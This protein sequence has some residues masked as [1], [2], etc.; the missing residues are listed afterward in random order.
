M[1][2]QKLNNSGQSALEYLMTYGWAMIILS[3]AMVTVWQIG[4]FDLGGFEGSG[5]SGFGEVNLA[6]LSYKENRVLECILTNDA[7]GNITIDNITAKV[8][9]TVC[10][11]SGAALTPGESQKFTINNCPA[12]FQGDSYQLTLVIAFTDDRTGKEHTSAGNVWGNYD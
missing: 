8:Y 5:Y 10:N 3:A 1:K 2:N 4:I 12:G 7:G 9:G 11:V 6:G